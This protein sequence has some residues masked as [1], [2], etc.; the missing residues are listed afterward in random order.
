MQSSVE[1]KDCAYVF[2]FIRKFSGGYKYFYLY[3]LH[4]H[5]IFPCIITGVSAKKYIIS[6]IIFQEIMNILLA[7]ICSAFKFSA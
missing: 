5:V 3:T 6:D 7:G 2:K 4:H 1:T